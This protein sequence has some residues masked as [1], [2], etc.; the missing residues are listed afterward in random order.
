MSLLESCV[1]TKV[2]GTVRRE[3]VGKVPKGNSLAAYPTALADTWANGRL[4]IRIENFT[5]F[6]LKRLPPSAATFLYDELHT[7]KESRKGGY[8][9]RKTQHSLTALS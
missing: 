6:L 4:H 9:D 3:A 8:D 2:A 5:T 1:S 7:R